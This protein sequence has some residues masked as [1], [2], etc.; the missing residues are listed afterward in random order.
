MSLVSADISPDPPRSLPRLPR[1]HPRLRLDISFSDLL[2][3]LAACAFARRRLQE[4]SVLRAWGDPEG[5]VCLSVRSGFELLLDALR[6]EAGDEIAFSAITHPDM[7]RI[8]EARGLRVLPVDLDLT[9]LAPDSHALEGAL[10]PR[11]RLIVSLSSSAA[12]RPSNTSQRSHA[13]TGS[14]SSRTARNRCAARVIAATRA[15][16]FRSSASARSRRRPPWA[17]HLSVLPT[18]TSQ[19]GCDSA[20]RRGPRNLAASTPRG[21]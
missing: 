18:P 16:T 1:L 7:V 17:V 20:S 19:R 8:A 9:S 12:R 13:R 2:F 15:R 3:A 4:D 21:R 10:G 6:L 14:S 11:T 5:I